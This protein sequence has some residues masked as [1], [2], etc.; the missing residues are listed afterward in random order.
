MVRARTWLCL[1]YFLLRSVLARGVEELLKQ[2]VPE[3]VGATSIGQV[4]AIPIGQARV[5]PNPFLQ[6][7]TTPV[8]LNYFNT[9]HYH[10]LTLQELFDVLHW[11][12]FVV[13]STRRP[14]HPLASITMSLSYQLP[15]TARHGDVQVSIELP[16]V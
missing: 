2:I 5:L 12:S 7:P 8:P 6:N 10:A 9:V 4:G 14:L 15:V 11:L 1:H 13:P 16:V 3:Q